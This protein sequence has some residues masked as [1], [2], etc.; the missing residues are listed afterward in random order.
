MR[1]EKFHKTVSLMA[2]MILLFACG[3]KGPDGGNNEEALR[4]SVEA[5]ALEV[6]PGPEHSFVVRVESSVPASGFKLEITVKSERDDQLIYSVLVP[7]VNTK[8][9]TQTVLYLPRQVI[10]V[11][12]VKAV[13]RADPGN[14]ATKSFRLVYK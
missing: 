12:T 4:I 11:C 2:C 1:A 14:T 9:S 5:N 6:V 10:C 3:D 7:Q 8:Q 13:S